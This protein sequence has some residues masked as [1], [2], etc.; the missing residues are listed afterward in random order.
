MLPTHIRGDFLSARHAVFETFRRPIEPGHVQP[1]AP[2]APPLRFPPHA[3]M[4]HGSQ[5]TR[6]QLAQ[7]AVR[8]LLRR[9]LEHSEPGELHEVQFFHV[10]DLRPAPGMPATP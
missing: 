10:V 4:G 2:L 1:S 5:H 8:H 3:H 9:D 7:R 6:Q